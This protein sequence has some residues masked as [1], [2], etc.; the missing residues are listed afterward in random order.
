L[1]RYPQA[2]WSALPGIGPFTDGPFKIIHHTTEGGSASGAIATYKE[3]RNY[4]HFT[5]EEDAVYQH[6][7]TNSAV[8]A[9]EHPSGTVETNRSHA[10]QI[11][12]VGFAGKPKS[13]NSLRTMA[14]LC[15]WLEEQHDIP[16]VWP[17]GFP[18]PPVNGQRPNVPFNRDSTN[19][20]TKGGHYG[21]CHVPNNT[22]WDPGYTADEVAQVM[23]GAAAMAASEAYTGVE[24]AMPEMAETFESAAGGAPQPADYVAALIAVARGEYDAYHTITESDEPLR[25]RI[26]AYCRGI[27]IPPP[28]DIAAFAWS[29][30]FVSWCIK[31]AGAT[32]QEF[33]FSA[34]HA[35]FVRA[36]IANADRQIG[37]FR[38]RPVD[39]YAPRLSDLIHRNR[40]GGTVTYA[41]A[42]IRSDYSSHSAVVV[43][44]GEDRVGRYAMTIGGNESDSIRM[45]RVDLDAAGMVRQHA[46]N[47]FICVVQDLKIEATSQAAREAVAAAASPSQRLAMAK[48][49][50]DFE[51]RR[52]HGRL[53][54]YNLPPGDGGGRYEVAGINERYNKAVC[55]ELVALIRSGRQAE[56]EQRADA[57]IADN[58]DIAAQWTSN[59]GVEFYLRDCV[60]NRGERG[61][62]WI[63]QKAVGVD[64]DQA[65]G[66]HT[67]AAVQ[68][69]EARPLA[70]LDDLRQAR[71]AYERLRRDESSP[72]W[73]GLVNRW[74]NAL[75]AAKT[76]LPQQ[77]AAPDPAP[78]PSDSETPP[79]PEEL[80]LPAN[81]GFEPP[82]V[83]GSSPPTPPVAAA[84]PVL[85]PPAP[86]Y[87]GG[88]GDDKFEAP[89]VQAAAPAQ[90]QTLSASAATGPGRASATDLN[91]LQMH[92]DLESRVFARRSASAFAAEAA[93]P[94]S[95]ADT[96]VGVGIGSAH[97]DFESIGPAGPGAP[98]LNV[99]VAQAM[100]MDAV[101]RILV[102]DYRMTDLAPDRTPVNVHHTGPIYALAPQ[103]SLRP[104]PCGISIGHYKITAGTQGA[105]ARG[106]SPERGKRLLVLSNN[107][108]LANC[109][110]CATGDAIHQPGPLDLLPNVTLSAA[111]QIG[112]L[113][114]W[115]SINFAGE[116]NY[117]DCATAW[118]WPDR[119]R[120]DFIRPDSGPPSYFNVGSQPVDAAQDMQVGKV[121]RT[122][123]LTTGGVIDVSASF[124]VSYGDGRVANFRDQITITGAN[125][126]P[127]SD[128][129]DSGSLIWTWDGIRSPVGLL[130]AGGRDY[131]FAN[132]IS[133]VLQALEIELF[134]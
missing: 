33:T 131:T 35:V 95:L 122:T 17:N 97:R 106:L 72:F 32:R 8:T 28:D 114:K 94:T 76:F 9:L 48:V 46:A 125:G 88:G 45:T 38:A 61:A 92:K 116:P 93:D 54:V 110:D 59:P 115:V 119:V 104:S 57:Y 111:N 1:A 126:N 84:P 121:G 123:Q 105:L 39:I 29:A 99:Y 73:K 25:S 74:N 2:I 86:R 53:M 68:R 128:G 66:S 67:L 4:P 34:A 6:V 87:A 58:T 64:T 10:I 124:S 89:N 98:V 51:A 43:E 79:V 11:E 31:T 134:T 85:A 129:G 108:I 96:I 40:S 132:K 70:L 65:V 78:L 91:L 62:A 77:G 83:G 100:N 52:D 21:H 56:A 120:K 81:E 82:D 118:C 109:N 30:T 69:D 36:A 22:H 60:F 16:T 112:V 63:L 71:E 103:Q 15:R 50:V 41:E 37:V 133:H 13:R 42:R 117:V 14:A 55:D 130:F 80:A 26:D 12:L 27:G 5:V 90:A 49:I 3:T 44:V 75:A 101:K 23:S 19:W 20:R 47:P 127:F 18:Y 7:D 102:D 24:P 113:E 107:H